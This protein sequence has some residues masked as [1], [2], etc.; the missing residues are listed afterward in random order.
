MVEIPATR[1]KLDEAKFFYSRLA[2]SK[3]GSQLIQE[4]DHFHFYVSAFLSAARSVTFAL[5]SE[6]KD[7]YDNF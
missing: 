1:S 3:K 6:H 4:R 5:Q 7:L 2:R